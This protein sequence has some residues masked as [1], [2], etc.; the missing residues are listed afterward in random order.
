MISPLFLGTLRPVQAVTQSFLQLFPAIEQR[1]LAGKAP[2]RSPS[3]PGWTQGRARG[4]GRISLC[5]FLSLSLCAGVNEDLINAGTL[6]QVP[7]SR[8]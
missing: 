4:A 5:L 1:L 8:L 7:F 3:Q 2:E 6:A